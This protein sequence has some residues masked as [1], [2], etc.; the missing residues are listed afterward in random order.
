[1]PIG[2]KCLRFRY[3]KAYSKQNFRLTVLIQ[4]KQTYPVPF[5][6]SSSGLETQIAAEAV[7]KISILRMIKYTALFRLYTYSTYHLTC[8]V[9]SW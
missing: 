5:V 3:G 7:R 8:T 6:G 2:T 4:Y 1:M 9:Y